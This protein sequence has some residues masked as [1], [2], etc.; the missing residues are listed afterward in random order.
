MMKRLDQRLLWGLL[1]VAAGVFYLLQNLGYITWGSLV[2]AGAF[3][4]GAVIFL[5]VF[6]QNR[7]MW[8][9]LIPGFTLAGLGGL[10]VLQQVWPAGA[11][12]WGGS[13]FLGAIGASFWVI[14]AVNRSFWWAIIPGGVLLTLAAVAATGN[15]EGDFGGGLFFL[16]LAATFLLLGLSPTPNARLSWAFYPAGGLAVFGLL[17]L[18]GFGTAFNYLWPAALIVAG[19][20]LLFRAVRRRA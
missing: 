10:M 17:L 12:Q 19:A 5:G 4:V 1:L 11:D 7:T 8:W 6:I 18:V 14:Y 9:A 2:W 13:L 20:F 3:G 15:S 16:G